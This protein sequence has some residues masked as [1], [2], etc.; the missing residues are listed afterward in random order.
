MSEEEFET[1][2]EFTHEPLTAP[3]K[4]HH[5]EQVFAE[6]WALLMAMPTQYGLGHANDMLCA[7][8]RWR[9]DEVTQRAATVAATFVKW[10]GT[11]C[12]AG[13]IEAA[14]RMAV[15][16]PGGDRGYIMEWAHENQRKSW[17]NSGFRCIEH[18]L[19]PDELLGRD[20]QLSARPELSA[21]DYEV[22]EAVVSWLADSDGLDF[23][24]RCKAEL[25]KRLLADQ[26][27]AAVANNDYGRLKFLL[28]DIEAK[29]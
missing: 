7:V 1:L 9:Y 18:V 20:G 2:P 24:E 10:L 29:P 14:G 5:G 12:G 13:F 25:A 11:N 17:M 22:V 27:A 6:L 28:R 19:A 21:D 8:L 4:G 15:A 16:H 3:R 23:V 26:V